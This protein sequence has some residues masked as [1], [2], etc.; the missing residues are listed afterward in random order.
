MGV[1]FQPWGLADGTN[2]WD[3]NDPH[4][5]YASGT[6][7][8]ASVVGSGEVSNSFYVTGDLSAYAKGGYSIKNTRSGLGS[9]IQGAVYNSTA[10]RTLITCGYSIAWPGLKSRL[11]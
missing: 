3:Q 5:L 9:L 11:T 8:T 1:A 2:A 7:A 4:G 6:A 10:N